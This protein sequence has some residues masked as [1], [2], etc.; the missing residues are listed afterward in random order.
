[1]V[2]K[3]INMS[4]NNTAMQQCHMVGQWACKFGNF[5]RYPSNRRGG[6]VI[7]VN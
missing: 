5:T 6:E 2:A 7:G 1:M 4:T 3:S